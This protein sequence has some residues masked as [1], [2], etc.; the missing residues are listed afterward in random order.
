MGLNCIPVY[1]AMAR[2][3]ALRDG[4]TAAGRQEDCRATRCHGRCRRSGR[5]HAARCAGNGGVGKGRGTG[6]ANAKRWRAL[7]ERHRPLGDMTPCGAQRAMLAARCHPCA[8]GR[9]TKE[10]PDRGNIE[11]RQIGTGRGLHHSL[12]IALAIALAIVVAWRIYHLT[13][14]AR[15]LPQC[16]GYGVRRGQRPRYPSGYASGTW[17]RKTAI[18]GSAL[19]HSVRTGFRLAPEWRELWRRLYRT[20]RV[21]P[22]PLRLPPCPSSGAS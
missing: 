17:L 3:A 9:G 1:V 8:R 14:L 22:S 12:A 5:S 19:W 21:R 6:S 10:A 2:C 18:H 4:R 13:M 7:I 20:M 11:D 15:E 16:E